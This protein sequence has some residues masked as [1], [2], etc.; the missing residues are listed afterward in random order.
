MYIVTFKSRRI[1]FA[2]LLQYAFASYCLAKDILFVTSG[3]SPSYDNFYQLYQADIGP[4]VPVTQVLYSEVSKPVLD[5]HSLILTV[6]NRAATHINEFQT[7]N[8]VIHTFI[9]REFYKNVAEPGCKNECYGVYLDQP[10]ERYLKFIHTIF[11]KEKSIIL[12]V[13][14]IS[15]TYNKQA[16]QYKIPVK[17][18]VISN[19]DNISKRLSRELKSNNVLLA[20]P[21]PDI[22]NR[23]SAKAIILTTYHKNI[24]IIA[25]SK[26][27]ANA[28]A[29]ASLY[30]SIN[31]VA[32]MSAE[33]STNLLNNIKI[34]PGG[35]YPASYSI[36]LNENVARS[37]NIEL[38]TH[39]QLY[40]ALQK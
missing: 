37:L 36:E 7:R 40:E 6:G 3:T 20:L 38:P 11:K 16:A 19:E 25:Y 22:Y 8:P 17:Q 33:L 2:I 15:V 28:G 4:R 9:T 14:K 1:A 21:N 39:Q 30:S 35:Y 27:F 18:I 10:F 31:D 12:P 13:N 5:D 23:S 32:T 24:P 29:I 34:K 26:S